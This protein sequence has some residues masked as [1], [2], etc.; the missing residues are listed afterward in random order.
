[1]TVG[2]KMEDKCGGSLRAAARVKTHGI[3]ALIFEPSPARCLLANLTPIGRSQFRF[4]ALQPF[5]EQ[6]L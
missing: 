2:V 4:G 1:M 6:R 5:E 3:S